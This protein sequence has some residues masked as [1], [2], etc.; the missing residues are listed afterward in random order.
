MTW[1]SEA[2]CVSGTELTSGSLMHWRVWV[3]VV[4]V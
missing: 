1:G 2:R 4:V 3:V